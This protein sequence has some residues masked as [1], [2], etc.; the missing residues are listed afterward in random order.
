[1]SRFLSVLH[2]VLA[3][4]VL[5][6]SVCLL[7]PA[8]AQQDFTTAQVPTFNVGVFY[9]AR[10]NVALQ[11]EGQTCRAITD[12]ISRNSARFNSELVTNTNGDITFATANSRLMSSRMQSR[13]GELARGY[14]GRMT[15]LK[16]WTPYQDPDLVQEMDSLHYEGQL[17]SQSVLHARNKFLVH[18]GLS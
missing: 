10:S 6:C 9:P 16:A 14:S 3:G 17:V 12:R 11:A 13:L 1:M 2:A 5:V 18:I 8:H 4:A 15:V 7:L